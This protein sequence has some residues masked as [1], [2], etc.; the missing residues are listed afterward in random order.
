VRAVIP[1]AL[2]VA[3]AVLL[4][5]VAEGAV[6]EASFLSSGVPLGMVL[7]ALPDAVAWSLALVGPAYALSSIL[8][9][10]LPKRVWFHVLVP[11]GAVV[12]PVAWVLT[13]WSVLSAPRWLEVRTFFAYMPSEHFMFEI[14]PCVLT[15]VGVR[16]F[17]LERF[18]RARHG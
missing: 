1:G 8:A 6:F 7:R 11:I 16:W 13:L 17:A 18:D 12:I 5:S 3:S 14:V 15:T 10:A 4:A 2:T 9:L